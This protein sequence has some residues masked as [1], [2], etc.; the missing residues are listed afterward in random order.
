MEC[1]KTIID[2][3]YGKFDFHCFRW[4]E[5]EEDNI[6]TLSVGNNWEKPLVRIQSACYTAEIFRST[7]CDC[8]EQL[9][10]S[11]RRI[12]DE[13]GLFIYMLCDGR[14]AGLY[15]KIQG[16]ELGRTQQMDTADAYAH[17]GLQPDPREYGRVVQLLHH[18]N[19]TDLR[20]MT[21]NPRK[22]EGL[23][24]AGLLVTR[25]PLEILAT[26]ASA[27]YLRTKTQKMGH[28]MKQFETD[29]ATSH[30]LPV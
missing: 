30:K 7:D 24:K 28:L 21:N 29:G 25:E 15:L 10:T 17:L 12:Q 4:G 3:A 27:P 22:V 16:L 2:T 6:L 13:T 23:T 14:G 1:A 11:L 19:V 20:L 9:E 8:H 5:H 26:Q 18:F